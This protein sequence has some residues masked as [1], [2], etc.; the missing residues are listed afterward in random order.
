MTR[1]TSWSM[2]RSVSV[3]FMIFFLKYLNCTE[4]YQALFDPAV[5]CLYVILCHERVRLLL[6]AE[7][8][9]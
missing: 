6:G 4:K 5:S 7:L 9:R 8:K 3:C 1:I 2:N